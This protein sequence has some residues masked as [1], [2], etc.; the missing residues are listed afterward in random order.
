MRQS[1]ISSDPKLDR[2]PAVPDLMRLAR[3]R[4]PRFVWE[5]FAM[6]T[7]RETTLARNETAFDAIR[8]R[9]RFVRG[10]LEPDLSTTL[11]GERYAS[12]LGVAP[13]GMSSLMWPG[14]ERALATLA[15]ERRIA[16]CLSTVAA[17]SVENIGPVAGPRAWFQLYPPGDPAVRD[18]LLRRAREAGCRVLVVTVD[19]PVPSMRER[20]RRAQVAMPPRM[21]PRIVADIASRPRWALETLRRGSPRFL[22]L[23]PYAG[24]RELADLARYVGRALGHQMDWAWIGEVRAA[25]DGPLVLKGILHPEDAARAVAEGIDAVWVSNHGGRQ[26]DAAPAS[27]EALPAIRERLGPDATVLFDGGVRGGLDA[28]R[29]LHLGADF[30]LAGR[31]FVAGVAALGTARAAHA[32]D[33]IEGELGNVMT[34]LGIVRLDE[35]GSLA[36]L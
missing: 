17:D 1:N 20:A 29:A 28:L 22:N 16:Y 34:Q 26:L 18:D 23:E 21:T 11:F 15:R 5:Y 31:P 8:F 33:I 19:I 9:P 24:T 7:G 3:R 6:G 12:P 13:I 4:M 30:V 36:R 2:L 27:I 25:W 32:L 10:A 35:I 14:S